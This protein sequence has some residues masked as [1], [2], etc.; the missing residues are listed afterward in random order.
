M[1][2]LETGVRH[3]QAGDLGAYDA[4]VRRF[5]DV[6]VATAYARLGDFAA[7]QDAAQEA[8]L[9]AHRQLASLREPRAFPGWLRRIVFTQCDRI[10]RRRRPISVDPETASAL[11]G[12]E[13]DSGEL[14]ERRQLGDEVR[15]AI[16]ELPEGQREVTTLFYMG[17]HSLTEVA[18]L[19]DISVTAVKSRLHAARERLRERMMDMVKDTLRSQAPSRNEE[20]VSRVRDLLREVKFLLN[21]QDMERAVGFYRDVIGLEL[22][23]QSPHWSELRM[24]D[25]IIALHGGGDGT[26]NET[27]LSFTVEDLDQACSDVVSGGGKLRSGPSDRPGEP[28]RLA[29]LTDSEG[30]GFM[31]SE[32]KA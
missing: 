2:E 1:D 30:N 29:E 27:G 31:M 8:F 32:D 4:L 26:F 12:A 13:P 5:Q 21:A 19:L 16:A 9:V 18:G 20:F 7:A 6:A 25:A 23:V 11:A 14:V 22:K 3:A 28:I 10:T 24:G 15:A 17:D